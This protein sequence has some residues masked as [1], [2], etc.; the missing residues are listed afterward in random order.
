VKHAAVERFITPEEFA[1]YASLA[2]AKG[3]LMVSA[4]PLTRSSY[5]ADADFA[6]LRAAR[7][8]HLRA[9]REARLMPA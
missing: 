8:T 7:E 4:T 3:F 9:M 6:E 5:H 1:E 2:R